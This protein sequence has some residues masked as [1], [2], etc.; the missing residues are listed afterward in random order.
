MKTK[1]F[2]ALAP[3]KPLEYFEFDRRE[4]KDTDVEF[5]VLFCGVCHSDIHTARGDWGKVEYPCIPGHEIVGIVTRVGSLVSAHKLG[6]RV[7]VGS[8]GPYGCADGSEQPSA[9]H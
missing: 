5:K 1:S 2:A 7:G 6:D 4:P 3:N 8:N 9:F